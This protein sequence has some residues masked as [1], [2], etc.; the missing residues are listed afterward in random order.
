MCSLSSLF[1]SSLTE[2]IAWGPLD[3][4]KAILVQRT[5]LQALPPMMFKQ[6]LC[7]SA[8]LAKASAQS[9]FFLSSYTPQAGSALDHLE[10]ESA[11]FVNSALPPAPKEPP[12]ANRSC[13]PRCGTVA[14]HPISGG[15]WS[16]CGRALSYGGV[17]L[18][19]WLTEYLLSEWV[20]PHVCASICHS[21]LTS[22]CIPFS[23]S[24]R[25]Q[26]DPA[27]CWI[28]HSNWSPSSWRKSCAFLR[29]T[30]LTALPLVATSSSGNCHHCPL[31]RYHYFP[32][33]MVDKPWHSTFYRLENCVLCG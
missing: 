1:L 20:G 23:Q 13:L 22:T 16:L 7:S 8:L 33:S 27:L 15:F 11:P 10:G 6:R 4:H 30:S 14:T 32:L 3:S 25:C 24:F 12:T 31:P 19:V 28:I 18:K 17:H 9:H 21:L 29:Q 2:T 26:P 5:C